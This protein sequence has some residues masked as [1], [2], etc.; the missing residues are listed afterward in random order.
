MTEAVTKVRVVEGVSADRFHDEIYAAR[1]PVL[2]KGF[3]ANWP[4]TTAGKESPQAMIEYISKFDSGKKVETILGRP[5]IEGHFFYNEKLDGLN[6][7]TMPD[8]ISAAAKRIIGFG[9]EERQPTTYVQSVSIPEYLPGFEAENSLEMLDVSV[10]PRIWIGNEITVQTHFDLKENIAC[11]V[12]GRRRFTLFPPSQTPNLYPGPFELTLSGPP[13]S[14]VK[15]G[16]PDFEKYPKFHTAIE[17]A[18]V[19][20]LEPGDAIYIPYLWWHHVEALEDLNVLVNF[21]WDDANPD[22]G[23]PYDAM[24]HSILK[25]RD[26]PQNQREAWRTMFDHYV[27]GQNGD[28]VEHLPLQAHGLLGDHDLLA[29][30]QIRKILLESIAKDASASAQRISRANSGQKVDP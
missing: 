14:M 1:E 22:I 9:T 15:L 28:P 19:A 29:R 8:T 10:V 21:W 17:H 30:Q 12:A 2:L 16:Q 5:E 7:A 23:S 6:F 4:A 13:V 3:V 27:F 24:L 18:Q 20:V 25:I 11:S 26:L